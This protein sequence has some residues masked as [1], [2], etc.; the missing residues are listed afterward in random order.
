MRII[1]VIS[2]L[3]LNLSIF[4]TLTINNHLDYNEASHSHHSHSEDIPCNSNTT[5]PCNEHEC[6][7]LFVFKPLNNFMQILFLLQLIR[8]ANG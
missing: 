1:L 5:E 2:L 4:P 8:S 3:I 7:S 6:C